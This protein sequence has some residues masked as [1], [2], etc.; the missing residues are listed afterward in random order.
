MFWFQVTP[1][2][3]LEEQKIVEEDSIVEQ[4][5]ESEEE[6]I[7]IEESIKKA[8]ITLEVRSWV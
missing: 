7:L 4:V 6:M 2:E 5:E 1:V 3:E 8:V